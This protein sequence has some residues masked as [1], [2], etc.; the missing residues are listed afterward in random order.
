MRYCK[1]CGL[2]ASLML[3]QHPDHT[4]HA[5]TTQYTRYGELT[6]T[7]C[8]QLYKIKVLECASIFT[9]SAQCIALASEY[10]AAGNTAAAIKL[11]TDHLSSAHRHSLE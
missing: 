2:D 8:V 1:W 10:V 4:L 6:S 11:A 9:Q 3:S 5:I 7:H